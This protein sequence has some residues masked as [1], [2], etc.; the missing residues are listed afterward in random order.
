M[1]AHYAN[2][3]KGVAIEIEAAILGDFHKVEYEDKLVSNGAG[4]ATTKEISA[5]VLEIVTHKTENWRYE[6]E[7]RC[8]KKMEFPGEVSV[9][10]I[11][12]I[13]FGVPFKGVS[14]RAEILG[15]CK[16]LQTH[17][18]LAQSLK[19]GAAK[20]GLKCYEAHI[21]SGD[22]DVPKVI[23]VPSPTDGQSDK[24]DIL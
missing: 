3:F 6:S 12:G 10:P 8:L 4:I 7:H 13:Y 21:A 15:A 5:K 2:G 22:R 1:W 17:Q 16:K 11:T 23:I 14:N 9:G 19:V 18:R 20:R 24:L